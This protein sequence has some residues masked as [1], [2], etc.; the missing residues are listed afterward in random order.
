MSHKR[1]YGKIAVI[2]GASKGIGYAIAKRLAND[3]ADVFLLASNSKRLKVA[4]ET[5]ANESGQKIGYFASDLRTFEGCNRAYQ[6]AMRFS[7]SCHFLVNSAGATM[8]GDFLKQ[9]DRELI[10]GFSLKLFGAF[11]LCKAFWPQLKLGAGTVINI[12]G[13][14]ART[15][16][17]DFAVATSVNAALAGFSK[18]LAGQGLRDN[19]NVNWIHPGMTMT[20]RMET[21]FD[22]RAKLEGKSREKLLLEKVAEEKIRRLGNPEDTAALVAFLCS[23]EA[24]HINGVGIP[25]DG[26]AAKGYY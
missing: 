4:A 25:V 10:D 15:P 5:I 17:P 1:F 3:G 7:Q 23:S 24:R 20:D 8:G 18:A 22:A 9:P 26:G 16:D 6:S 13:G 14:F 11:R 21:I 19:I 12:V 2:T